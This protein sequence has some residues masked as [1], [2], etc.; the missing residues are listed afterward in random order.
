[1]EINYVTQG[2]D[3]PEFPRLTVGPGHFLMGSG[4]AGG[5]DR[6][7]TVIDLL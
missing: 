1:V 2:K 4:T 6:D 3:L 5:F 7:G